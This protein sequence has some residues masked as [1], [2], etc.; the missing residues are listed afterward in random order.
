VK[1][2]QLKARDEDFDPKNI[3][4]FTKINDERIV[5]LPSMVTTTNYYN[6]TDILAL[7]KR[8]GTRSKRN[9]LSGPKHKHLATFTNAHNYHIHSLSASSDMEHYISSD[10]VSVHLWDLNEVNTSYQV[11]NIAPKQIEELNE[12]ITHAEYHPTDPNLFLYSSSKGH[13]DVCD[14]RKNPESGD[15]F[16]TR[17]H[18]GDRDKEIAD[19][20]FSEIIKSVQYA[21]FAKDNAHQIASRDYVYMKLW[22]I[23]KPEAPLQKYKIT[24]Y[25]DV[26]L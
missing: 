2:Y 12:V 16:W 26:D 20:H 22:D 8:N 21:S 11:V 9:K 19:N 13:F 5:Q 1:L 7:P 23:R 6:A 18:S 17:F 10:E 4:A 24:D 14:L 3:L 15:V 25:L